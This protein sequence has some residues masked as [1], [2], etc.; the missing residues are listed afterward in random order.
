MPILALDLFRALWALRRDRGFV[1]LGMLVVTL[2]LAGTV[3]YVRVEHL[4]VV[5]AAY[6]TVITLT[7]VGYGDVAP[8]TT[9]GKIF[10]SVFVLV[11]MGILV[12]FVTTIASH[13][14]QNSVLHGPIGRI[15]RRHERRAGTLQ[16]AA[17]SV[18][19][20]AFGDYDLLVVGSDEASRRAA[21]D[22]AGA[23]LRVVLVDASHADELERR[24][25]A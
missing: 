2:V 15:A 3:F 20:P 22:A 4:S 12:A 19:A 8:E 7:T 6:L 1:A 11:G 14:R 10:T 17:R 25:A 21:I 16:E 24:L 18:E 9:A 23:G 13:I 5:D